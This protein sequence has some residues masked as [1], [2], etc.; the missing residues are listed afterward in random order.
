[1]VLV[2]WAKYIPA[3]CELPLDDQVRGR[4]GEGKEEVEVEEEEEG[5]GEEKEVRDR[6]SEER[7]NTFLYGPTRCLHSKRS[8]IVWGSPEI[9]ASCRVLD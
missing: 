7:E 1:M 3:F 5:E 8:R 4:R 9:S 2:E 6:D